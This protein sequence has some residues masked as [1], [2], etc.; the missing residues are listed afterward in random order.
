MEGAV[1][2]AEWR[3]STYRK[4]L[5]ALD[6]GIFWLEHV[7]EDS[8]ETMEAPDAHDA[9]KRGIF[10]L[11]EAGGIA[12]SGHFAGTD[13]GA[14]FDDISD[15]IELRDLDSTRE[16]RNVVQRRSRSG[17]NPDEGVAV[18]ED[19]DWDTGYLQMLAALNESRQ[20]RDSG[21]LHRYSVMAGFLSGLMHWDT[22]AGRH[23]QG[24]LRDAVIAAY[25]DGWGA[26]L[27]VE[28]EGIREAR[29]MGGALD[30]EEDPDLLLR[31][32][33]L[34]LAAADRMTGPLFF[35]RDDETDDERD[36]RESDERAYFVRC[37]RSTQRAQNFGKRIASRDDDGVWLPASH[38][39]NR[40]LVFESHKEARAEPDAVED[41]KET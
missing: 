32:V 40:A 38:A 15:A 4:V 11:G 12:F 37:E 16:I 20:A 6:Q 8:P 39:L 26:A 28:W 25:N 29:R 30:S 41:E 14:L 7:R 33:G 22:G 31:W 19:L 5:K 36:E 9:V 1:D 21:D 2:P 3:R 17:R 24:S 27:W 35:S 10:H 34:R 18:D 13:S 23:K